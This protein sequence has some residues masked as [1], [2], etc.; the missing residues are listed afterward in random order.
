MPK[1]IDYSWEVFVCER[2]KFS[3]LKHCYQVVMRLTTDM[4][5]EVWS[6]EFKICLFT[7]VLWVVDMGTKA[8]SGVG[9][10]ENLLSIIIQ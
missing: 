9:T 7:L 3:L 8:D 4:E 1:S 2:K 10:Q 5:A 6:Q